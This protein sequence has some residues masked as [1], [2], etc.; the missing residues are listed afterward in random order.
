MKPRANV[1]TGAQDMFRSRLDQIIN[2]KHALV[3]LS[4]TVSWSFIETKCGEVYADGPGMPPLPTRL[5]A[6]LK[7]Y[8]LGVNEIELCLDVVKRVKIDCILLAGRYTLLDRTAE[9]ELLPLCERT[10]TSI[11]AGGVFNSG[12]LAT[13]WQPGAHFDYGIGLLPVSRT[14]N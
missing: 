7:A 12:I 10:D 5:M 11:V 4:K 6:G 13:G 9:S 2:L 14:L 3:T 8:G 1:E